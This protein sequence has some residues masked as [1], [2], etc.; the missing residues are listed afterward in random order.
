MRAM[1]QIADCRAIIFRRGFH[2]ENA[3]EFG[4]DA[5]TFGA[6]D[7]KIQAVQVSGQIRSR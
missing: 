6:V 7:V 5:Q 1:Q 4:M 3:N 2:R